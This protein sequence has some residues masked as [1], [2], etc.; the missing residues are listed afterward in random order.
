MDYKIPESKNLTVLLSCLDWGLG[1]TTRCI[2]IIKEFINHGFHVVIAATSVQTIVLKQEISGAE[3]V[4][5]EGYNIRYSKR[6]KFFGLTIFWQ[7]PKILRA[8]YKEKKL[9]KTICNQRQIDLIFSDNRPGFRSKS[10]Y[11][12]YL[13]HQINIQTGNKLTSRIASTLHQHFIKKFNKCWIPDEDSPNLSGVLSHGKTLEIP[14][15]YI[16]P[17]SRFEKLNLEKE[18]HIAIILSGPEPQRTILENLLLT[19]IKYTEK[20]II[21]VRGL[22]D[23]QSTLPAPR[24]NIRIIN[25]LQAAELNEVLNKSAIIL[26]RSGYTTIMDLV[27]TDA[28]AILIPTP[29]QGEQEYL[30]EYLYEKKYFISANQHNFS[31]SR[32]VDELKEIKF[33]RPPFNFELYKDFIAELRDKLDRNKNRG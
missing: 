1:H 22:P 20:K 13:T 16:G 4:N 9:I 5:I 26:S 12:I 14:I 19:Q 25:H 7:L 6:K 21:L 11:S 33:I 27:K 24:P 23:N 3:F 2:P 18:N 30:A 29:G 32:S 17:L 31:L 28:K 8:I 10:I 15:H